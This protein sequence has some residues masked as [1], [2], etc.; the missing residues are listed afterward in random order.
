[1]AEITAKPALHWIAR[2][3][4]A[5]TFLSAALPKILDPVAF[6]VS[7]EAYRVISGATA[8]W[9]ALLLPWLELFIAFGILTPW[10]RFASAA[11][12]ATLLIAFISLH[13]TSW[14][15]G[16]DIS[17]GCFGK[18]AGSSNYVLLL[19]RNCALL[20]PVI[21]VLSSERTGKKP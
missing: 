13:M 20:L 17:C 16:L 12:I 10:L 1:M 19:A 7:V 11:T 8:N 18:D 2:I 5:V 4:L 14:A 9:T 3:V 15:R 6:A 21:V